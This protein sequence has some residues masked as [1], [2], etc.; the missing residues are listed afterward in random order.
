MATS[1]EELQTI[2]GQAATAKLYSIAEFI[3]IAEAHPDQWLELIKGEIIVVPAP[4]KQ[5][6]KHVGQ[7][8]NLF[9]RHQ[10]AISALGC[11]IGGTNNYFE[12]TQELQQQARAAGKKIQSDVCPDASIS[13]QD[14]WDRARRPPALLVVEVLSVSNRENIERDT[15][16]K[17]EIYAALEIPAYWVIDRRDQS[18]W[19]Y[20]EPRD[21]EYQTV[22]QYTGEQLLPAPGLEF[23][24]ITPAQIFAP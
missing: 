5:H 1:V 14:Y 24:Q 16:A 17:V 10:P 18:I 7:I 23:L 13:Y 3:E 4:D 8:I 11:Q 12:V 19:V 21:A 6:Q 2:I 22:A 15:V 20:T 9:A